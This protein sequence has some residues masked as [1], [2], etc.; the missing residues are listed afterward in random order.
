MSVGGGLTAV[1]RRGDTVRRLGGEWTPAVH[2]LL[3]HLHHVGFAATN[4]S[5]AEE[6][7]S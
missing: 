2:A 1:E 5:N 4:K 3:Q 7:N 6:N